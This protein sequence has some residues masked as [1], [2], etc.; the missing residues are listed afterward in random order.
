MSSAKLIVSTVILMA[1]AMPA[2][3][4]TYELETIAK[5]L[6]YPWSLAF[7]PSGDFLV[8]FLGGG[9]RQISAQGKIGRA[10]ENVPDTYRQSQGG[11]F[12]VVLD[13]NFETNQN[14][15]LAFAHGTQ[16]ENATRVI[17]ARYQGHTLIDVETIFTVKQVKDTPVHYGGRL[18]F[19]NDGTLLL[20]TGDG[21]N[22]REAAQDPFN[23]MG[24][25]LRMNTDGSVP[26]DNPFANGAEAD[27]YIYS[28]GHRNPQG[29]VY[30]GASHTIY[31]HEHG[32]RGGD[33]VNVV[34]AGENYGWPVTTDGVNYSG[35][36]ITPF[37]ELE[38]ITS[39]AKVWTPSVAPSGLAFYNQDVFPQWK[40]S[41]FV[42]TLVDKDVRRL[43]LKNTVVE[44]EEILFSEIQQRIRDVRTGP[45]GMIYLLS[46]DPGQGNGKLLRVKPKA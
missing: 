1:L 46:E 33:E 3:A 11:F 45:D 43:Q 31:M 37:R 7:L 22:Y 14:I 13:P 18:T 8:S 20:T 21:F 25:I 32:P 44:S 40:N 28:L 2:K 24:K 35:A 9:L 17:K 26:I 6:D 12:D 19:I 23:Q 34:R 39:P 30:D 5:N 10:I 36:K 29:L 27:P 41:L 4:K 38:G 16:K 15:Y 42:G